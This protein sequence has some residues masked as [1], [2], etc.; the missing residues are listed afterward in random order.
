MERRETELTASPTGHSDRAALDLAVRALRYPET[1]LGSVLAQ[2]CRR[3]SF[4]AVYLVPPGIGRAELL[5]ADGPDGERLGSP[6]P[7]G[8]EL[9]RA[10]RAM[11]HQPSPSVGSADTG[12]PPPWDAPHWGR[13]VSILPEAAA[14][15]LI[16][17]AEEPVDLEELDHAGLAATVLACALWTG[18]EIERL[19]REL[20]HFRQERT[21]LAAG[22][23]HDMRSGLTAIL[24]SA[25]TLREFFDELTSE[26]RQALLAMIADQGERVTAMIGERLSEEPGSLPPVSMRPTDLD[27]VAR[28]AVSA[29][30]FVHEGHVAIEVPHFTVLTDPDRLERCLLNLVDNA[31]RHSPLQESVHVVGER[32]RN[33]FTL[34]VADAGPGVAPEL[35]PVLFTPYAS[36]PDQ[37]EGHGLGLY[38]VA[39]VV[40]ELEGRVTYSRA[41]GWTR[42]TLSV[43]AAD[44]SDDGLGRDEPSIEVGRD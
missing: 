4:G 41:D 24:G 40:A 31:L 28:R 5:A 29:A 2:L 35:E 25:G 11:A 23:Y 20:H 14:S 38:S 22:L 33:G 10:L 43:P 34:T 21:L 18:R 7:V 39:Q 9:T 27:E 12:P 42:F 26:E 15:I 13:S 36:F 6:G 16:V 30:R 37:V 3:A 19:R 1:G 32:T 17:G 44:A 8:Q